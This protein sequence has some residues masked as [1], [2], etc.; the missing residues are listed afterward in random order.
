MDVTPQQ[1]H[2]LIEYLISEDVLYIF[3]THLHKLPFEARKDVQVIFSNALRW[4]PVG[5]QASDPRV[6]QWI[7]NERPEVINALCHGYDNRESAMVCGTI[8]REALKFDCMAALILYDEPLEPGTRSRGLRGVDPSKPT[9][10]KGLFWDFFAWIDRGQFEV[11][12]DSFNT[13]RVC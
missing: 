10:G 3:A 1:I 5:G 11:S 7:L 12:A 8:L 2:Q 6:I 13:L 9:S 4:K